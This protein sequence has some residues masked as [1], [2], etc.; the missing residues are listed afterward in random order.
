MKKYWALAV[1][2][3]TLSLFTACK[4]D[5]DSSSNTSK[6]SYPGAA[7][8]LEEEGFSGSVLV[9]KG[10]NYVVEQGFGWADKANNV[11]NNVELIYRIGSVT[12]SFTAVGIMH[13]KRDGLIDNLDQTISDFAPDFPQGDKITLRHLMT[14]HSGLPEYV[15]AFE[16]AADNQGLIVVTEDIL[17]AIEEAVADEGLLFEPGAGFNYCNSNYMMLGLLIEELSGKSYQ[18][19]LEEKVFGPLN[20]SNTGR[21]ADKIEGANVARGYY[22]GAEV[23]AYQMNIAF[24]AGYLEST[25]AD[26]E[27]WGDA[28]MGDYLTEAEKQELFAAPHPSGQYLTPGM[29]WFT[30]TIDNKVVYHHGGDIDGFTSLLAFVPE[31]NSMLILLSNEQD[32]AE[33]RAKILETIVKNEF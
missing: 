25:I 15:E 23:G 16:D 31:S 3:I 26:L 18:E 32:K 28:M 7:K 19:Y 30:E 17:E 8:F 9:R 4:K 20:I 24:S 2:G 12:K 10:D 33:Q 1:I 6:T 5:D 13:L 29:G 22:N 14:H 27:L 21:G 11:E